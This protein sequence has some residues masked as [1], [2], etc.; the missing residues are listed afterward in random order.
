MVK[1]NI[2]DIPDWR[3]RVTD[4]VTMGMRLGFSAEHWYG[5]LNQA[6][7]E[8]GEVLKSRGYEI[9]IDVKV[10]E[11]GCDRCKADRARQNLSIVPNEK[12]NHD[13]G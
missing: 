2:T 11:C 10:N 5:I 3:E 8:L 6:S 9:M 13:R 12:T 7:F 4:I 1:I